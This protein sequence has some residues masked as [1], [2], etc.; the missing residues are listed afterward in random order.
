MPSAHINPQKLKN[1]L[2][3]AVDIG[4]EGASTAPL[5]LVALTVNESGGSGR[6]P[7]NVLRGL[8]VHRG[9]D[10]CQHR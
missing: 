2:L 3:D 9:P 8:V 1:S 4:K 10:R 7:V 5:P 6:W